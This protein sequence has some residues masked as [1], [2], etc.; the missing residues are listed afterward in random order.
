MV[1][2][3]GLTIEFPDSD[4]RPQCLWSNFLWTL[5]GYVLLDHFPYVFLWRGELRGVTWRLVC[6]RPAN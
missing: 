1:K 4:L 6:R 3:V 2:G 5:F